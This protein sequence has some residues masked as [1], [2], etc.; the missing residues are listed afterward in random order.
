VRFGGK[1]ED[2]IRVW[3]RHQFHLDFLGLRAFQSRFGRG[4]LDRRLAVFNNSTANK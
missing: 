4:S 1:G 3:L 2:E